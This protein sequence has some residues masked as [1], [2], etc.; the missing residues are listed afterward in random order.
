MSARDR[1]R[2]RTGI[3]ST[4]GTSYGPTGMGGSTYASSNTSQVNPSNPRS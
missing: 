3:G 2:A 1:Y 4:S